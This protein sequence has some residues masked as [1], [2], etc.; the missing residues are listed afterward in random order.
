MKNWISRAIDR[1]SSVLNALQVKRFLA[2]VVVGFL[3]LTTNV[4]SGRN[5]QRLTDKVLDTAHEKDSVRPKTTNEWYQ[6]A[7]ETKDSPGERLK[8]IAEESGK[9]LK[10]FGSVY[11][12]TAKTSADALDENTAPASRNFSK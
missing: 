10:E 4:D 6:E 11:P 5:N 9:A 12:D 3:L 8:N 1:I 7:R 2:V